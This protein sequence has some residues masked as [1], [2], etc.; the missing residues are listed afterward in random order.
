MARKRKY[1]VPFLSWVL[2]D[3]SADDLLDDEADA[4]IQLA[5]DYDLKW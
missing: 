2:S 3:V 5:T 1:F 4:M